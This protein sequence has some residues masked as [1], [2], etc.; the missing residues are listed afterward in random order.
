MFF[1]MMN[2]KKANL[3]LFMTAKHFWDCRNLDIMMQDT[4]KHFPP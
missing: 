1:A 2:L 3:Q 4:A